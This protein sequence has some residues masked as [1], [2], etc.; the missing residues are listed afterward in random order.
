MECCSSAGEEVE[1]HRPLYA[2]TFAIDASVRG[3]DDDDDDDD[4]DDEHYNYYDD[5]DEEVE[6]PKMAPTGI[7]L[8]IPKMI[9][10]IS[11]P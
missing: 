8:G 1:K 3:H 10:K 5:Y 2:G 7:A 6:E 11:K 9:R 4:D